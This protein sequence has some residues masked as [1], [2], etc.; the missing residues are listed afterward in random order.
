M[1]SICYLYLWERRRR[2]GELRL[3]STTDNKPFL[4]SLV[5]VR[6][7]RRTSYSNTTSALASRP[8]TSASRP[9]PSFTM[10]FGFQTLFAAIALAGSASAQTQVIYDQ[11]HNYTSLEG[12]WASGSQQV[13]TGPVS[14]PDYV[15]YT[16]A[17]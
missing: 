5:A 16:Q 13:L 14:P 1:V 10:K 8:A 6:P 12:T 4:R 17:D 3:L 7:I 11:A 15:Q 2:K 9:Y